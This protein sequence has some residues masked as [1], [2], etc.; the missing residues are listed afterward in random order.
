V[1]ITTLTRDLFV[2]PTPE[3]DT[4]TRRRA[5]DGYPGVE[6]SDVKPREAA[7]SSIIEGVY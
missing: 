6:L 5:V 2:P 4:A 3:R 1:K 7:E